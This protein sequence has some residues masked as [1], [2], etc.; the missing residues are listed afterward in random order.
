[1]KMRKEGKK[2]G[3]EE[4]RGGGEREERKGEGRGRIDTLLVGDKWLK[5]NKYNT[6]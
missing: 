2:E 5:I 4:V 6:I 3:K 1:M